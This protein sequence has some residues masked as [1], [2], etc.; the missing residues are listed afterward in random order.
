[1]SG[2]SALK[3]SRR[4]RVALGLALL[5]SAWAFWWPQEDQKS[6]AEKVREA[7]QSSV[8]RPHYQAGPAPGRIEFSAE[9]QS[10]PAPVSLRADERFDPF[11]GVKPPAAPPPPPTRPAMV[12]PVA[13]VPSTAPP[14][15]YRFLGQ[16]IDPEGRRQVFLSRQD[17]TVLA[18]PGIRLDD[19]Y[20]IEAVDADA[21]RL[22]HPQ[23][24]VRVSLALPVAKP[25]DP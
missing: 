2:V 3:I 1:M 11:A 5:A 14:A 24:D 19:G 22:H 21:V 18:T 8:Q 15:G 10:W 4:V 12:V 6:R 20:V 16:V 17:R 25:V 7:V 13:A 23:F 9:L